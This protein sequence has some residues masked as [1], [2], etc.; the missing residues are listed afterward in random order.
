MERT[1]ARS[2]ALLSLVAALALPTP[3]RADAVPPP[4]TS[5]PSE[6]HGI[7]GHAGTGCA[8]DTCPLGSNPAVCDASARPCC[9]MEVCS[10]RDARSCAPGQACV[11][12]RM[13]VAPGVIP[14]RGHRVGEWREAVSY[15]NED[16]GCAPGSTQE[17]V[18]TCMTKTT[19]AVSAPGRR[20]GG[21]ICSMGLDGAG[22]SPA[23]PLAAGG[24]VC[25]GV[26]ARRRK[27]RC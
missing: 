8:P 14:M 1:K 10:P 4:P 19:S 13:C 22:E 24:M 15:V 20:R 7:T 3:A 18:A 23:L 2:A 5:C 21:G 6:T 11:E 27:A 12:V 16:K 17:I 9:L 25:L 26:W